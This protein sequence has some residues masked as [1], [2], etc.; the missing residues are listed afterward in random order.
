MRGRALLAA[1]AA[2]LVLAA[3]AA[4][5]LRPGEPVR[6][7]IPEGQA[8]RQTAE[9][10]GREGVVPSVPLFRLLLRVTGAA[11]RLQPGLYTFRRRE[12]PWVVLDRMT[13]G[14]AD[15]VRVVIPEGFRASQIAERLRAGRVADAKEFEA[16]VSSAGLEGRLFPSTYFF[17]PD[18][19]AVR[20]ALR[21]RE[22][23]DKQ[24]GDAY[25]AVRPP[26]ALSLE[27][28]LILASI[29]E[30]EAVLKEERPVIAA[31]YLNRLRR[32]MPLQADPTVQ[33][34]LGYWKKGLTLRD[35]KVA[36][37]YNTYRHRGLPPGPIC[38]PGL[39]SFEA[40]LHPAVTSALYFV[41]D[42]KGGHIFS[43]TNAEQ[44]EARQLYK[45]ELKLI[46]AK[47]RKEKAPRAPAPAAPR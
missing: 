24:I 41:A 45:H 15:A 13:H 35:L 10:L 37:P 23:F 20:A 5:S 46:K 4:V 36:S 26:P 31:V 33:Y 11:R 25:A 14:G 40:V 2:A 27:D 9:L 19:G 42:A 16:Y 34:A 29:V 39:A 32:R 38:S 8:A 12:L 6:V 43:E 1:G 7:E 47:L 17:P 28:A 22:T 44:S 18:Y 3:A 30:R 21:M